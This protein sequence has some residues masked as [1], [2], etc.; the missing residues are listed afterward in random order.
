MAKLEDVIR[1]GTT[2]AKPAAS[3]VAVGT[4]Y[5]DTDLDKLQ[6]SDGANWQDVE[7]ADP[8][9]VAF[10]GVHA[11]HNAAQT[12]ATATDT[13]VA[14]NSERYDTDA[15]HDNA[16]NNSRLTVPTGK[17]GKY[18]VVFVC[19]FQNVAGAGIREARIRLNGTTWLALSTV[20]ATGGVAT[21]MSVS[22]IADLA[23]TDYIQ[24]YVRQES[25]GNCDLT[26]NARWSPELMMSKIG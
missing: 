13:V 10:A 11:Y 14:L 20:T 15:Y 12:I 16:T 26:T 8:S 3:S 23:V 18:L 1:R 21:R 9:S 24:A 2:A 25:G 7:R 6:R 4:L 5:F 17:A 19:E 22:V